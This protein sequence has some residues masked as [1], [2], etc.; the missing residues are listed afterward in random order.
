MSLRVKALAEYVPGETAR[1]E[2]AVAFHRLRHRKPHRVENRRREIE[3]AG[4]RVDSLRHRSRTRR[5]VNDQRH[6][7]RA[8]IDEKTVRGLAVV[9]QSLSV[10]RGKDD[11]RFIHQVMSSEVVPEIRQSRGR[12]NS[13]LPL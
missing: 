10:V 7:Q 11:Q 4:R 8:L 2:H 13:T 3:Q 1:G 12:Y 6:M 5:P 9:S